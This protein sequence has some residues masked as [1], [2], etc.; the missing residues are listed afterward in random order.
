M[1]LT[2]R[3]LL[4]TPLSNRWTRKQRGAGGGGGG[5]RGGAERRKDSVCINISVS[6][7][8]PRCEEIYLFEK[9]KPRCEEIYRFQER[10][11][12]LKKYTSV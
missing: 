10:N 3:P 8:K 12:G 2:S 4:S 11:Q 1:V 5:G 9:K 7:K 6:R